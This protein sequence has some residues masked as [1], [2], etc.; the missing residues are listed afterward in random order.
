MGI[1][2]KAGHG[3]GNNRKRP[4]RRRENDNEVWQKGNFAGWESNRQVAAKRPE[5]GDDQGKVSGR[6]SESHGGKNTAHK[7]SGD[8]GE[9]ASYFERPKWMPPKMKL[10]PLPVSDCAWCGKPIRDISSAIA[11]KDSGAPVHFDCV[12]SRITFGERLEKGETVTY[13]GGG[14]FGIVSFGSPISQNKDP[15]AKSSGGFQGTGRQDSDRRL[16][17]PPVPG[18]DF[19]I[20]KIIEW[21]NKEKRAEWRSAICE[22]YSVT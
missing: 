1:N 16:A 20:K 6:A 18:R 17:A 19:T 5:T 13:I 15:H 9:R 7:K 3:R 21:E 8:R 11:D 2:G 22:H 10:E 12:I 4:F 14:R